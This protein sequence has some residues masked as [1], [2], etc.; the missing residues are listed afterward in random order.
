MEKL[1]RFT[2]PDVNLP[3]IDSIGYF[4]LKNEGHDRFHLVSA[5]KEKQLVSLVVK[6]EKNDFVFEKKWSREV[7]SPVWDINASGGS[8]PG[9][10]PLI[11]T[12][13]EDGH[14]HA[15]TAEGVPA[16]SHD[17]LATISPFHVYNDPFTGHEVLLIPSLDK[18]LRLLTAKEGKLLWGDTFASGVNVATQGLDSTGKNHYIAAGGNDHTL[19]LYSRA[20]D[21]GSAYKMG[22]YCKFESYVR[23][24]SLSQ[25][26]L[27]AAVADD[28]FLKI[29][30]L[31][32]GDEVWRHEH[33][34]FAWKCQVIDDLGIVLSTS[35]QVPIPVD[36]SGDFLGN[37]GVMACH[38]L[39]TGKMKWATKPGDGVNVQC[40]DF[41]HVRGKWLAIAGLT[42]GRFVI[43]N[44]NTGDIE[45]TFETGNPITQVK[46][47]ELG[48][49]MVILACQ[50]S[51]ERSLII[52][53]ST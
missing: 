26:G 50:E 3:E 21:S 23:D 33:N 24:A 32:H 45:Q 15:Y 53:I 16:W 5:T 34:S 12:A 44:T 47:L 20:K 48:D 43:I 25:K 46:S 11:F 10:T 22:W 38:D 40:W 14:F 27:V 51:E 31:E 36:E 18:T 35:F 29:L 37:P 2:N 52:G 6:R 13:R 1:F 7:K 8:D 19:R 39:T 41:V 49:T 42:G 4:R 9:E 28:G 30:D 17:F